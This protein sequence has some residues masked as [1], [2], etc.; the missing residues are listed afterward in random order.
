MFAEVSVEEDEK[1][2]QFKK[3]N[4][5]LSDL[6]SQKNMSYYASPYETVDSSFRF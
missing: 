3:L 2:K 4:E 1:D 6:V 5:M